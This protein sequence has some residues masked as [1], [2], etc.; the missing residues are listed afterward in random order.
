MKIPGNRN[1]EFVTVWGKFPGD[2]VNFGYL[3]KTFTSDETADSVELW[4]GEKDSW[5]FC[6]KDTGRK[7]L[8]DCYPV[9]YTLN[10]VDRFAIFEEFEEAMD[11]TMKVIALIKA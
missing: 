5:V 10:G 2:E 11:Y 7:L 4:Y 8:H 9:Q 1:K 6:N 3:L